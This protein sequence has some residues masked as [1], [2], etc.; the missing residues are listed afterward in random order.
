M[1]QAARAA[2]KHWCGPVVSQLSCKSCAETCQSPAARWE[3][4]SALVV[5]HLR[6]K[7]QCLR[8]SLLPGSHAAAGNITP[9]R[10]TFHQSRLRCLPAPCSSW[11][12]GSRSCRS[13]SGTSCRAQQQVP[14][15]NNNY[16][17]WL[18]DSGVEYVTSRHTCCL[19]SAAPSSQLSP[20]GQPQ[21]ALAQQWVCLPRCLS[22]TPEGSGC[23]HGGAKHTAYLVPN[24]PA[25]SLTLAMEPASTAMGLASP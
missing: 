23:E 7:T 25:G 15:S 18:G 16:Q 21:L 6:L 22:L 14:F 2:G 1:V 12:P 24:F 3:V 19:P 4:A 8:C 11:P 20:Q 9:L 5:L 13:L 17:A 10:L